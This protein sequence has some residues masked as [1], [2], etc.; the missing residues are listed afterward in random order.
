MSFNNNNRTPA[1]SG[2]DLKNEIMK[3]PIL[4]SSG[5][6]PKKKITIQDDDETTHESILDQISV[7]ER[8]SM[9]E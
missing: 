1:H 9:S 7:K 2:D 4:I 3:E 6:V 5:R 8:E